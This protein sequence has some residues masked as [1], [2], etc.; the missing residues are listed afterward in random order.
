MAD[1]AK[2]GET[3]RLR[4]IC[5]THPS[6]QHAESDTEFGL[7]D[8]QQHLVPGERHADGSLRYEVAVQIR[9]G[10]AGTSPRFLGPY[11]HG[12]AAAPFLYLGWRESGAGQSL[13]IRRLKIPLVSLSWAQIRAHLDA[14]DSRL[15]ATVDGAGSGT[16]PLLGEGWTLRHANEP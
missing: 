2:Q 11:V 5:R 13:W 9:E 7:Q 15:E 1:T 4:I 14:R 12:T 6:G 8:R 3:I 10:T 16:V